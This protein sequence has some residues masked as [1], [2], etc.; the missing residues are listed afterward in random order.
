[1]FRK[2]VF[3]QEVYPSGIVGSLFPASRHGWGHR[4]ASLSAVKE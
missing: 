3:N 1:M 2:F 4:E